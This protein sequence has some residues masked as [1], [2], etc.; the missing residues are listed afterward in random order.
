MLRFG[1]VSTINK[2]NGTVTV[3]VP[4]MSDQ[5]SDD[6]PLLDSLFAFP[7]VGDSVACVF[8]DNGLHEGVCL[9][10]YFNQGYQ[11]PNTIS[12]D[13][14]FLVRGD[15]STDGNVASTGNITATGTIMDTAGNSSH[16]SH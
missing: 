8:S 6:I 13:R 16:H 5:V 12:T 11:P 9:G 15:L 1:I 10:R 2:Q 3:I 7:A 4:G 14:S